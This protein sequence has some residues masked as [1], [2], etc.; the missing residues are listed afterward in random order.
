[1]VLSK[2]STVVQGLVDLDAEIGKCDKKL[3]LARL[4]LEKLRKIELQPNYEHTIPI[5][6][7]MSNEGKVR[8][9]FILS[10]RRNTYTNDAEKD[11][12]SGNRHLGVIER[13]VCKSEVITD[14][15]THFLFPL[16]L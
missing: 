14:G 5:N 9:S 2:C 6:V 7:R 11:I 16:R 15:S 10:L 12:R 13:D 1:V 8:V 3:G 4:N